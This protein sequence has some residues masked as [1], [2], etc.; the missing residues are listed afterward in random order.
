VTSAT[1]PLCSSLFNQKP[2]L[3]WVDN[4]LYNSHIVGAMDLAVA[5]FESDRGNRDKCQKH[6]VVPGAVEID[7]SS[8][9]SGQASNGHPSTTCG[10]RWPGLSP[11]HDGNGESRS[12][13]PGVT[14]AAIESVF[15]G[16][17]AV[18]PDPAHS[19]VE[20]RFRA[21]GRANDKRS[22]L[23]V[24]ILRR[25]GNDLL[26]RPL[27]ARYMHK[28]EVDHYEAEASKAQQ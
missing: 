26:I 18:F 6:G 17:V 1:H 24:F 15:L 16:A 14:I 8:R 25:R 21:I 28:R 7:V 11:G 20:E 4:W 13:A 5:G 9:L 3:L 22:V 27:S 12:T 2:S 19:N 10:S 23:I